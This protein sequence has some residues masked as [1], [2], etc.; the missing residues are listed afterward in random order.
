MVTS[1]SI[2]VLT[3]ILGLVMI[4]AAEPIIKVLVIALGVFLIIS[5]FYSMTIMSK[6][7]AEKRFKIDIY[8]RGILS[9]I[10]GILSVILPATMAQFAWNAMMI[11]I[12]VFALFSAAMEIYAAKILNDAGVPVKRYIIEIIGTI[13]AA[14]VVFMLP[15]SFGFALIKIGG[16]ALIILSIIMAIIAWKNRDIIQNDADV[17]DEE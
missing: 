14:I 3:A 4:F 13:I 6:L 9:I 8:I 12:G 16:I 7:S 5:G 15:S 2:P 10:L 11:I 17:V 1:F